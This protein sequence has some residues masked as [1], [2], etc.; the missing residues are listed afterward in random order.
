MLRNKFLFA[1]AVVL[2]SGGIL[3]GCGKAPVASTPG[4]DKGSPKV[5]YW[6]DPMHPAYKSDKPGKAP[7]CGM[8][9]VPVYEKPGLA[10]MPATTAGAGGGRKILYWFDPMQPGTH[11]D[12]PGKSPSMN[13][14]M[15]PQY[16]DE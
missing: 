7:D 15:V 1:A 12:H 5:L 13:M 11:F 14:E 3:A 2:A 16:A 6:V 8:D 9:L 4:R 10:A